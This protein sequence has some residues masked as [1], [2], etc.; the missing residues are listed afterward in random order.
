MYTG[1]FWHNPKN[2]DLKINLRQNYGHNKKKTQCLWGARGWGR[3]GQAEHCRRSG[4][5]SYS[6]TLVGDTCRHT[7]VQTYR[8]RHTETDP[9]MDDGLWAT[10]TCP[11]WSVNS[12]K[13]PI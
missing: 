1:T 4:Q 5:G 8:M 9:N 10:V 13:C 12:D 2:R 3:A 7:C 6:N 11:C